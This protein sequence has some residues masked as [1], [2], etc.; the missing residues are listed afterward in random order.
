MKTLTVAQIRALGEVR[1]WHT[2]SPR[3]EQTVAEHSDQVGRLAS[4]LA[5][6]DLTPMEQIQIDTLAR[7]HDVHET[8][9]GDMPYP[10]KQLL[11]EMGIDFDGI[12]RRAFWGGVD[13]YDEVC[14]RV[15]NLVE[16]AD[17]LEAALFA[18]ANLPEVADE[19]A[20]Q[21]IEHARARLDN[22][23]VARVVEA[24]GLMHGLGL[25]VEVEP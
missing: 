22:V 17:R 4:L 5:Y 20:L 12:C 2:R 8:V 11:E 24:L 6:P 19:V 3:R 25:I 1:R 15:R 7:N 23:G 13:P 21:A 18:Q 14:P 9:Y 10:A 16:V